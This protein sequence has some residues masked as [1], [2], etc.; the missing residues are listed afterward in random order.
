MSEVDRFFAKVQQE[1]DCWVW[2]ACKDGSGYGMFSNSAGRGK[3]WTE[4]S[5]R[6]SYSYFRSEIPAGLEID[7]LCRNR[8]CVNPWHM[9][10]VTPLVNWERGISPWRL[11]GLKDQCHLGHPFTPD[12]TY[13]HPSGSRVCRRC[14]AMH[15]EAYEERKGQKRR[16]A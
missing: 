5:H 9:E 2:T 4:R 12:N 14:S 8:G 10:P 13:H 16:A 11:N 15:R 7:H 6:W 3:K 1:G